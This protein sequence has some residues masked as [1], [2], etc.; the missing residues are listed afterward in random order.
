MKL[1]A[2]KMSR[3]ALATVDSGKRIAREGRGD[4]G[5]L[6]GVLVGALVGALVRV[7][8]G[9]LVVDRVGVDG[10]GVDRGVAGKSTGSCKSGKG[11]SRDDFELH[12]ILLLLL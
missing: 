6:V 11:E 10:V 3:A 12:I 4:V 1:T 5:A 8:L 9:G 7:G 2:S